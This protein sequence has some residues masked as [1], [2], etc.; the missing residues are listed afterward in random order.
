MKSSADVV[1]EHGNSL[2]GVFTV[3]DIKTVSEYMFEK[4]KSEGPSRQQIWQV[5]LYSWLLKEARE[6]GDSNGLVAL[7]FVNRNNGD[8]YYWEQEY[9]PFVTQQALDWIEECRAEPENVERNYHGPGISFVCDSCKW[10]TACWGPERPDGKP[11]QANDIKDDESV[12][13][14]LQEYIEARDDEKNAKERKDFARALLSG[15]E[16]GNYD[17]MVL[18]WSSSGSRLI[19]DVDSIKF[20]LGTVPMK[21]VGTGG[22]LTVR[23]A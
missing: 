9:D 18:R 8:M 10:L 2:T 4:A 22:R 14:A 19:P 21:F 7:L 12:R 3:L 6:H 11:R 13:R 20:L 16:P 15:A 17:G 5:H 23:R 1:L